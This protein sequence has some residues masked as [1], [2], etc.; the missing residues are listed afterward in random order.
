LRHSKPSIDHDR[1]QSPLN[2]LHTP[3]AKNQDES[4]QPVFALFAGVPTI[5]FPSSAGISTKLARKQIT[6]PHSKDVL[7]PLILGACLQPAANQEPLKPNPV[8]G[9]AY[10]EMIGS[11][12]YQDIFLMGVKRPRS[13]ISKISDFQ[14]LVSADIGRVCRHDNFCGLKVLSI[15]ASSSFSP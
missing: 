6:V 12:A 4:G 13:G 5:S 11:Q 9:I 8:I 10:G 15:P 7:L 1:F 3:R 14:W 2:L